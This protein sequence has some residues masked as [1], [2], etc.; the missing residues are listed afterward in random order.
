MRSRDLALAAWSAVLAAV[1]LGP[2]AVGG[3]YLLLRDAVSTPRS[4]LTDTALGLGDN[5]ARATPQDWLLAAGSQ[6]VDGGLLVTVLLFVA[7]VAAGWGFG[8]SALA[9]LAAAGREAGVGAGLAAAT[10]GLW[11]PFVAERLLQ[12]HWSLLAGYAAIG[13]AVVVG[14]RL[15]GRRQLGGFAACLAAGGLTPTGAVLALI[16]GLVAAP[17]RWTWQLGLFVCA[18]APWLY[19]SLVS[20]S[21]VRADP[22]SVAVFAARAEPGLGTFGSLLGLGGIWNRQAV[23]DGAPWLWTALALALVVGG[24]LVLRAR[25]LS[26]PLGRFALLALCAVV[27]PALAA[28]G[29][30]TALLE[31]VVQAIPGSGLLRDGQKWVALAVPLYATCAA[32]LV[33]AVPA[34]ARAA[35]A[36]VAVAVPIAV[37]PGLAWG[38]GGALTPVTYPESWRTVAQ[39]VPEDRGS[40]A[41]LPPGMFR[42]YAYGPDAP[43]LD[44]APR[45]LRAPVLQTGELRVGGRSVDRVP[46]A[47]SDAE[48]ALAAGGDALAGRLAELGVGWVLVEAVI[49]DGGTVF[50]TVPL[51]GLT[52]TVD[53]PELRLYRVPGGIATVSAS[54]AERGGAWAAHLLWAAVLLGGAVVAATGRSRRIPGSDPAGPPCPAP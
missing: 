37:L 7:L 32:A 53:T 52:L 2:L 6:V 51:P 24:L 3:R 1:I 18:A 48:A 38:V 27:L 40:V 42:T 54:P 29:P 47:A 11:N 13:W 26:P 10:V 45:M 15:E 20:G 16:A 4:Y 14:L 9:I 8:R 44:P 50:P 46:G 23:P 17:R 39:A 33:A 35:G 28:T 22:A 21:G 25:L 41:V 43:V 34:A 49:A 5:A 31:A 19:P 30:G 12:G 36:V